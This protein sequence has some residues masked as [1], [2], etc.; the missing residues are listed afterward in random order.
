MHTKIPCDSHGIF[1]CMIL[2]ESVGLDSRNV[3][4]AWHDVT[5]TLIFN[6]LLQVVKVH[7]HAKFHQPKCR[8]SLVIVLTEKKL[9]DNAENNTAVAST[10]SNNDDD[11]DNE[12]KQATSGQGKS[13]HM[14]AEQSLLKTRPED[15]CRNKMLSTLITAFCCRDL[16]RLIFPCKNHAT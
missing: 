6:R 1:V 5:L 7:V 15:T 13:R 10:G 12:N 3:A 4:Q 14:T 9:S 11:C 2:L 8:G 16:N